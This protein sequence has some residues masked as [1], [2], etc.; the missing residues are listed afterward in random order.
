MNTIIY[1]HIYGSSS[2][3]AK[4]YKKYVLNQSRENIVEYSNTLNVQKKVLNQAKNINHE[5]IRQD[6]W[7]HFAS[8]AIK[9][10]NT[11]EIFKCI[12]E[13]IARLR[14]SLYEFQRLKSIK[15]RF[16]YI[17]SD[18]VGCK[19]GDFDENRVQSCP[20]DSYGLSKHL[21]EEVV[22]FFSN[23][24]KVNEYRI[25]RITNVVGKGQNND[26]LIP[27]ILRLGLQGK[28][29]DLGFINGKRSFIDISDVVSGLYKA[30]K[31]DE[32]NPKVLHLSSELIELSE[33]VDLC[34]NAIYK[35]TGFKPDNISG[36]DINNRGQASPDLGNCVMK[37]KYTREILR[38]KPLLD[39]P[40][41]IVIAAKHLRLQNE[42]R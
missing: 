15:K 1:H 4:E 29:L 12:D 37:D 11:D 32:G 25:V 10:K 3:I 40:D 26:Q 36:K 35:E 20:I 5:S 42:Q 14:E 17:S 34:F 31:F 18:R 9:T 41:A 39:I 2:F 38:W 16:I 22:N 19:S 8:I 13:N 21:S 7:L 28:N 23:N 27:R 30:A 6:I 24:D 33:I